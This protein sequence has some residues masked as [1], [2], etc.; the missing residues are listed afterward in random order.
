MLYSGLPCS[1]CA[2]HNTPDERYGDHYRRIT[3]PVAVFGNPCTINT[4]NETSRDRSRA[5]VQSTR[6]LGN[7][8]DRRTVWRRPRR[9][10]RD[11]EKLP[12]GKIAR[13]S[14][15]QAAH[16]AFEI[17]TERAITFVY[18]NRNR[19]GKRSDNPSATLRRCRRRT[20]HFIRFTV[21]YLQRFGNARVR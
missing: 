5:R 20:K 19:S 10:G 7:A 6:R 21:N 9:R 18:S 1:I 12:R 8:D 11:D 4:P 15:L 17:R 16:F 13:P 14:D 3:R 2:V